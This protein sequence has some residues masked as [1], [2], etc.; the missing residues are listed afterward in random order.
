MYVFILIGKP[1]NPASPGKSS[2]NGSL[3]PQSNSNGEKAPADT[4]IKDIEMSETTEGEGEVEGPLKEQNINP[5]TEYAGEDGLP[6]GAGDGLVKQGGNAAD[7]TG[8][9]LSCQV[10][11]L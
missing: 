1:G 6:Q 5:S 7:G 11:V 8:T 4:D 9:S 3:A 10:Q 2:G